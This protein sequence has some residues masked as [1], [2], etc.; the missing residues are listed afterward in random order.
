MLP[1]LLFIVGLILLIKGGDW[2]VDGAVGIAHRFNMPEILI[3][4]TVVSIGTTLPEVMVSA[5]SAV[6]GIGSMA[7]GNALGSIICNTA[8]IAAITIA[9]KPSDVDRKSMK[10]PVIFF[11]LAALVYVFISYFTGSFSRISGI[12]LLILFVVY[13][14]IAVKQA[15]SITKNPKSEVSDTE[16]ENNDNKEES[17]KESSVLKFLVLLVVGAALIAVGADLLVDNGTIIAERLGVPSTVIALTYVKTAG[18]LLKHYA[19][20]IIFASLSL[21]CI[22]TSHGILRKRNIAL[23]ASLATVRT[24]YDEYRGRVI[25]DLGREMDEHFLYDTKEEV[26]EKEVTDPETGKTK[27]LKE[28]IQV[29]QYQNAYS[30]I[31]DNCNAPDQFEKDGAANYIFIRSQ[32][33][34]L[35]QKLIR[36]G[37]LFL[38][39]AYKQ[40]GFPITLAGQS[41]GWIYDYDNKEG[42]QIF[43]EGFDEYEINNSKAVRD[44]MN[45]RENS[46]II[47]FL[48]IR[49]NI[50]TDIPR[51]DS[52]VATI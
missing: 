47:N 4:A 48:N 1:V 11:T 3:G 15:L 37:Y 30:R 6:K 43:F 42:T 41:A 50:L 28:K 21:T 18:K 29:P 24:A 13:M 26:R 33:L 2:F 20:T 14:I 35:Q 22:L 17:K 10:T 5:G 19:P 34:Y 39:D 12:L 16:S 49:D 45:G 9:V 36:D 27:K 7:Y 38:N 51:V 40:L 46:I 44:L 25:R 52:K 31:F 32:M 23:A 8:L